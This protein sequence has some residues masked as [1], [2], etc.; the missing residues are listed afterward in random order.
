ML[1]GC[2]GSLVGKSLFLIA[3]IFENGCWKYNGEAIHDSFQVNGH[4][5][6]LQRGTYLT[7]RDNIIIAKQ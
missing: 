4:F 6:G 1:V 7:G 5:L 2:L 3:N